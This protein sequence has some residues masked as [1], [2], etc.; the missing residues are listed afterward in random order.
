[1]VCSDHQPSHHPASAE[2]D[3]PEHSRTWNDCE[4][5]LVEWPFWVMSIRR[6]QGHSGRMGHPI[7]GFVVTTP[8]GT[9]GK[10]W[11][12]NEVAGKGIHTGDDYSTN[13]RIGF[14]V[15]ATAGGKVVLVSQGADGWGAPF[16]THVVIE[17]GD[18]RHGYCHLSK[19]MVSEGDR[20][21]EGQQIALSGNSG[22]NTTAPHL[23][24][25]E[26]VAPFKFCVGRAA[27]ILN[28]GGPGAG[29]SIPVGRVRLSHLRFG[30]KGS[31]SV[32][33]LQ[34]VLNGLALG[35]T[36]LT[37]SGDYDEATRAE[38]QE[39][40]L[41]V[42]LDPKEF[43]DGNLGP[44]QAK[45]IFAGTGNRLVDDSGVVD[46]PEPTPD[47]VAV[48]TH[49]IALLRTSGVP[50]PSGKKVRVA[51][52]V[53]HESPRQPG[54]TENNTGAAGEVEVNRMVGA[55][56]VALLEAD[57]RFDARLIPGL[58][59]PEFA[60]PNPPVDAFISLHCDG[61]ASKSA[62]GWSL[63]FPKGAVNKKLA[64]LIAAEFRSFHRSNQR[65]DNNTTD[66][67]RYYAYDLVKTP[68]PEVLVEHGFVSNPKERRWLHRNS[69]KLAR[70][71]YSALVKHFELDTLAATTEPVVPTARTVPTGSP[72]DATPLTPRSRILAD[73]RVSLNQLRVALLGR[74][75]GG[76]SESQV[77]RI[78]KIYLDTCS[79]VGV[80]PLVAAAQ[81]VLE[82]G[83]LT[84]FWSQ[85]PR[86][87]PAGIGVT[88]APGVGLK[89]PSWPVA[90]RAHVGRLLAYA[91]ADGDESPAQ[92]ALVDEALAARPLPPEKRA[93]AKTLR[94]L[95]RSWA[96][97][98]EYADKIAR[99]ANG[100]L[101]A[102]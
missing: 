75:H 6:K 93:S 83:N 100:I 29:T 94:G 69:D 99:V 87:N 43:A 90:V 45:R 18:R 56:L 80:D 32:K 71:E 88:G 62:D 42:A 92:R 26:R 96:T 1:M 58:V 20:V 101:T 31:D 95:A 68:G 77:R 22:T 28:R 9:R 11:S 25:E 37:V 79:P 70:A 64:D 34:D 81:M 89:F 102:K 24:Y 55:A 86:R 67:A 23:H 21:I 3:R 53:G 82:T 8:F 15:N 4:S 52:Q 16:G 7:P 74:P 19:V 49:P 27:P 40:Q 91:L 65:A 51:V 73:P 76:Y 85:P 30:T 60:R 46:G 78:A 2:F 59:P 66:M 17:T 35:G 57:H 54:R 84:S 50:T 41:R 63:G 33:R 36:R 44:R 14:P 13:K 38:V 5:A 48:A 72:G 97:D 98:P 47:P 39:W 61:A 10:H 12:C